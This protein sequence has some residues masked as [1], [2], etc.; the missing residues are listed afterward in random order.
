MNFFFFLAW[1]KLLHFFLKENKF[2]GRTNCGAVTSHS[3]RWRGIQKR[4]TV[5]DEGP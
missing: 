2:Y 5:Q 3:A 1:C 4:Q